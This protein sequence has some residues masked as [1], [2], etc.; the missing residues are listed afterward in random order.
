MSSTIT[1]VSRNTRIRG[2]QP[3]P[4][5][6]STPSA[7]AV[8]VPMTMPQPCAP[9]VAG[10]ERQVDQRRRDHPAD[11]GDDRRGEPAALAQLPHV[12]LAPDLEPDDEEEE[13]HQPVVDPVQQVERQ[14]VVAERDRE[15]R[16]PELLVGRRSTASSPRRA[17]RPSPRAGRSR[18]RSGSRRTRAN[19]AAARDRSVW[20]G[21]CSRRASAAGLGVEVEV[22]HADRV[23]RGTIL[24]ICSCVEVLHDVHR[25]PSCVCGHVESLCG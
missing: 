21:R 15:L 24:S 5:S 20:V 1:S 22:E 9:G 10:G 23:A 19:G 2:G 16:V 13:R 18:S 11:R 7:N 25:R 12:E 17:R 6:A 4:T 14:L 3:R 8:S